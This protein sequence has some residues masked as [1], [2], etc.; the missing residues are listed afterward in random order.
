MSKIIFLDID[1]VLYLA[2]T[3]YLLTHRPQSRDEMEM[4]EILREMEYYLRKDS[5]KEKEITR[6]LL[7]GLRR[8]TDNSS[9]VPKTI[10]TKDE[11][12]CYGTKL[13]Y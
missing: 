6:R 3:D 9:D 2:M 7:N 12:E 5:M 1:G 8:R 10:Q 4:Y 11:G 13:L